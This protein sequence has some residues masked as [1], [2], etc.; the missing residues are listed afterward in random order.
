MDNAHGKQFGDSEKDED[1]EVLP[2]F[3]GLP[4]ITEGVENIHLHLMQRHLYLYPADGSH[5]KWMAPQV[6]ILF[7]SG[8]I[9]QVVDAVVNDLKHPIG[10]GLIASI[11]VQ[12][13]LR[14][15]LVRR[16]KA[17]MEL[18]DE[19][20]ANHPNFQH[21]LKMIERMNCKSVFI[22]E[23]DVTDKQKLYGRMK[24]R[25]PLVILDFPQ[26][27][28]GERPS[29]IIT[30]NTFRNLNE[31][32]QLCLR[33][34]LNFDTVSVWTAKLTEGYDLVSALAMFPNFKFNC[35]NVP[36]QTTA[37]VVVNN[38]YHYEVLSVSGELITIVFPI[39]Y[40]MS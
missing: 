29:A 22:E 6:I 28:F 2:R 13:P 38:N 39:Q 37:L 34:G 26:I 19:R 35:I 17:R 8:H 16:L 5:T 4:N 23:F 24:E 15:P 1:A 11:L 27:Y 32:I 36:F 3:K 25:S 30:L 40:N 7:E 18:M 9:N 33:E 12:E 31:A 21:T 14:Q 10:Y 20:I